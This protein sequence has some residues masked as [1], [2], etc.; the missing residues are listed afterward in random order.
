MGLNTGFFANVQMKHGIV[1]VFYRG[2]VGWWAS[3]GGG[4][5]SAAPGS[6]LEKPWT[7][8]K[9]FKVLGPGWEWTVLWAFQ[10]PLFLRG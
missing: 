3:S 4:G 7:Q 1:V 9:G 5:G 2:G 8:C 10:P 6:R